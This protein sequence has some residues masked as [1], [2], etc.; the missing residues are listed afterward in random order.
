MRNGKGG[1]ICGGVQSGAEYDL[2]S[3]P[4]ASIAECMAGLRTFQRG[5]R[6]LLIDTRCAQGGCPCIS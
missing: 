6:A 1:G 2:A 4:H 5:W 3:L